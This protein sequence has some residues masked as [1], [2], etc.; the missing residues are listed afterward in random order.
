[1]TPTA[2]TSSLPTSPSTAAPPAEPTHGC[3]RCGRPVGPGV[4][5][6][7]E[8]NP[9]GLRDVAASQ[10]HGTV[11]IAVLVG[12]V[13]L[14]ILARI[15][16]TGGGPYPATVDSVVTSG[17]GLAVTLTVTNEGDGEG[18]TTCRLQDPRQLAGGTS[19][20]VLT[21]RIEPHSTTT[22]SAVIGEFGATPLQLSVECRTP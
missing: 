13:L 18:Q 10:V 19:A 3:A 5:L 7:D 8:C 20:F 15:A 11:I 17:T 9:L 14:A 1:V 16:I 21:P 12:F 4:G 6:C 2:P 22:F